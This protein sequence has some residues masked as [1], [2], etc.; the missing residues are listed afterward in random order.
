MSRAT[1]LISLHKDKCVDPRM[2]V[3]YARGSVFKP[4]GNFFRVEKGQ[5]TVVHRSLCVVR[6]YGKRCDVCPNRD[7]T[8]KF[9]SGG[10]CG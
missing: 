6:H 5:R 9:V 3:C 1:E 8:L 4:E 2:A 10:D 7:F